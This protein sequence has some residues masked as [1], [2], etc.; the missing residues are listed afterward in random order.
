MADAPCPIARTLECIGE[1]WSLLIIR[2]ALQGLC[3]FDDFQQSL[4]IAPAMLTR[5]LNTLI[6]HRLLEKKLYSQRPPRY[7]YHLTERGRDLAPVLLTMLAWGN[8]HLTPEGPSV[9]LQDNVTHHQ[10][11]PVLVDKRT[12]HPISM[13]RHSLVAG[14]AASRGM[15]LRLLRVQRHYDQ[16]SSEQQTTPSFEEKHHE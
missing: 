11:E 9:L 10:V 14:P 5:R 13:R 15:K 16:V 1:W 4:S 6:Q 7:E 8:K 2:D 3:R 12:G